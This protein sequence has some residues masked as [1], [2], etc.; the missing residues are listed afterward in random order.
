[1]S[2]NVN[3]WCQDIIDKDYKNRHIIR[4]GTCN[5]EAKYCRVSQR[6]YNEKS[7]DQCGLRLAADVPFKNNYH[8][9]TNPSWWQKKS[10][11]WLSAFINWIFN[12]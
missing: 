1:M 2:G 12:S 9:K 3:E 6:G 8:Q 11:Q 5:D 4:G 7:S 10:P